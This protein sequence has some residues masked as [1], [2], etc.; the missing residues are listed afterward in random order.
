MIA[1]TLDTVRLFLHVLAAAIW[2]GGQFA[3]AGIVPTLR[4]DA[5]A[6][7]KA[8]AQAFARMAWPSC[9]VLLAT[10]IWNLL[11]IDVTTL[12][13]DAAATVFVHLALGI[14]S[15]AFVAVHS[16]GSSRLALALGGALGALTAVA[17]MFTGVL[18]HG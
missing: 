11:D 5:P 16:L 3:L 7:T 14:A 17:A 15:G 8:V 2:V 4:R 12:S 9:A 10:G 13:G 18:L 6:A 1:P